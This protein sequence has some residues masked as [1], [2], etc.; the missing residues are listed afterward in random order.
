M[1]PKYGDRNEVIIKEFLKC[2]TKNQ[3]PY[4]YPNADISSTGSTPGGRYLS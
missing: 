2:A 1:N 4:S 3:S